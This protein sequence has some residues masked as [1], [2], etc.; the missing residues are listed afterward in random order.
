M[1]L[2]AL[3]RLNSKR[4]VVLL[5]VG[6]GV[7]DLWWFWWWAKVDAGGLDTTVREVDGHAV[8]EVVLPTTPAAT[9]EDEA[10]ES[11]MAAVVDT[12]LE[13]EQPEAWGV[14]RVCALESKG[15]ITYVLGLRTISLRA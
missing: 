11:W 7:L 15:I 13:F 9:E 3:N 8:D 1:A 2:C 12:R 10:V 6:V 4:S 14:W 5:S